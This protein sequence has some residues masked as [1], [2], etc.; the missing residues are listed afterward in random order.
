MPLHPDK[1]LYTDG[2]PLP[3]I[4]VCEHFSGNEKFIRKTL[5][6]QRETARGD[7]AVF[8]LI[9]D[10]EDGAAAGAEKQTAEMV[11]HWVAS[12]ENTFGRAGVRIHDA[13]HPHCMKDV[14]IIVGQAGHKLAYITLP[15]CD[16]RMDALKVLSYVEELRTEAGVKRPIP[17]HVMI[18]THNGLREVF[19]IVSLPL[20]EG[21]TL[22]IMDFV[23]GFAGAIPDTAMSSPG[24]FDHPLVRRAK[25][26]IASAGLGNGAIPIHGI[27]QEYKDPSVVEGDARR[28]REEF[29][30]LRMYSIHPDQIGPIIRGMQPR[31]AEIAD[32]SAIL[33][34]AY[35][36]DWGPVGYKGKLHDRAS[37][38]YYWQLLKR[39]QATGTDVP[40]EARE[41]FF[42]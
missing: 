19:D 37:F 1:V 24:Q 28:A 36:K 25:L 10:L 27:T 5:A 30:F 38:R 9:C 40:E 13:S 23:S 6:L 26:E 32:A 4:P 11:A 35:A 8:D 7:K 41:A 33:L 42:S 3:V 31:E 12:D 34:A 29:G 39:A 14:E 20:I 2:A 16:S 22:G 18:E 21:V 17:M 15:K